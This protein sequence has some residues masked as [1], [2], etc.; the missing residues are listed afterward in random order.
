MTES[1]V[2]PPDKTLGVFEN[3]KL[4]VA[5]IKYETCK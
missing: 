2:V 5:Y 3:K 1:L 4:G